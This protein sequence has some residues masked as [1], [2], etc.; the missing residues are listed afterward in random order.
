MAKSSNLTASRKENTKSIIGPSGVREIL[1]SPAI[2][3]S[4]VKSVCIG[5]INST[6]V[7]RVLYQ[8]EPSSAIKERK[9]LDGIAVVSAIIAADDPRAAAKELRE[10]TR[11]PPVFAKAHPHDLEQ[12][13]NSDAIPELTRSLGIKKPICHNMTNLVVQNI[14]ANVAL[15]VGASPIMSNNGLE[16]PDLANLGGSLV[17]NMGTATPEVLNNH[18]LSIQAYNK[19]GG[20]VV[21]DPV[22]AGA[23]AQRKAAVKKLMAS[24]YFD[25][26]K[27][28]EGEIKTVVGQ[29][30]DVQQRGVDSGPGTLTLKDK[31]KMVQTL[32][33]KE[34][35]VVLMTGAVDVVSNGYSTYAIHNGH[36]LLGEIT[37]SGCT[38]GTTVAAYLAVQR[39]DPLLCVLAALLHF[40]IA[41]ERAAKRPEVRGPGTF[42]PAWL[43]ELY[44]IKKESAEGNF[45]WFKAAKVDSIGT[46]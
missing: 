39:G 46:P 8:S 13:L 19:V 17:I 21:L 7:Q 30:G 44:L 33:A 22:G 3:R 25:L 12:S 35:N 42:V 18:I 14:A 6:N 20:P 4:N 16:A 45:D 31:V 38:L 10:L 32:A 2:A 41:A 11:N 34:R 5:G 15:S 1:S 37:G 27:G 9:Q 29:A 23:T 36:E 43:D 24:G 28:N 40:E 26:I